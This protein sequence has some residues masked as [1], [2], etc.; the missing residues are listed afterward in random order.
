MATLLMQSYSPGPSKGILLNHSPAASPSYHPASLPALIPSNSSLSSSASSSAPGDSSDYF[1]KS[2]S[3]GPSRSPGNVHLHPHSKPRKGSA[4]STVRRIRFAPLP[5]P[6]RDDDVLP[7][8]FLDDDADPNP[9]QLT[10]HSA[11]TSA[12]VPLA[13][14]ADPDLSKRAHSVP[15]PNPTASPAA[16]RGS[17]PSDSLLLACPQV[18]PE[19]SGSSDPAQGEAAPA[20]VPSECGNDWDVLSSPTLPVL[21][22]TP[23]QSPRKGGKWSKMLKPLLGRN[24]NAAN[25]KS[26]LGRTFSSEELATI[27]GEPQQQQQRG[28]S[29]S[30]LRAA[31][32]SRDSSVSRERAVGGDFGAPLHRWTSEGGPG[33]GLPVSKKKRGLL[34]G[35]G[36]GGSGGGVPLG[37]T[38]SLTSLSSK[39]EKKAAKAKQAPTS[40]AAGGRKPTRML[41]GRVYGARRNPNANPFANVRTDEPEFV[42]WGYGGMGSVKNTAGQSSVWSRVQADNNAAGLASKRNDDEDDGTGMSWVKRRKEERERQKREREERERKEQQERQKATAEA[43]GESADIEMNTESEEAATDAKEDEGEAAEKVRAKAAEAELVEEDKENIPATA[44]ATLSSTPGSSTPFASDPQRPHLHLEHITQAVNIPAPHHRL[45]HTH[46]LSHSH[47]HSHSHAHHYHSHSH[48]L[49]YIDSRESGE[50]ARPFVHPD[51]AAD[52]SVALLENEI[53]ERGS[54]SSSGASAM[55][56]TSD[57]PEDEDSPKDTDGGFVND[58]E[59]EDE[60]E[61]EGRRLTAL[62]AGVEKIARHHKDDQG[63][64]A[65]VS[66]VGTP[67]ESS[68]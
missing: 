67:M 53:V 58:E 60:D 40:A 25:T 36:G 4:P 52:S 63:Q 65:N 41:N 46:S 51:A 21:A 22:L 31:V 6:R 29:S 28:R 68:S 19:S 11:L 17:L 16:R 56:T 43:N 13:A 8:V 35:G 47:P 38:Q 20:A 23:P 44:I 30:L 54:V 7:P 9:E 15:S 57:D 14:S 62:G 59:S 66:A 2:P 1:S 37:R 55:S 26:P 10:M 5:E 32:S 34:F 64:S 48:S 27:N 50:M 61:E 39:E 18:S 42:E 49:S 12:G 3:P 33:V 24:N 45:H